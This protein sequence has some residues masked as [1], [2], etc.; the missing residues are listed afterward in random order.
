MLNKFIFNKIYWNPNINSDNEY[1]KGISQGMAFLTEKLIW[2]YQFGLDA[3]KLANP[4]I[5]DEEAELEAFKV[6]K[7]TLFD[8]QKR[9]KK[10]IYNTS[11]RRRGAGCFSVGRRNLQSSE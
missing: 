8:F 2:T 1:E 3:K 7:D 9:S 11:C 4:E 10:M 6:L 5:S